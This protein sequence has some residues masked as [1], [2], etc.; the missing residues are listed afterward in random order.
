MRQATS[1]G[2]D[3]ELDVSNLPGGLY[4][5]HV[6]IGVDTKPEIQKIIIKK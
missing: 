2:Q 6:D 1:N 3:V 5:V 4:Y